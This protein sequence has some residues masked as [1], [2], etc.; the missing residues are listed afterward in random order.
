MSGWEIFTWLNVGVLALGAPLVFIF[1][2]RQ[3]SRLLSEHERGRG[4]G[5][6]DG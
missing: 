3:L 5:S 1:F 6:P 2:L 4:G